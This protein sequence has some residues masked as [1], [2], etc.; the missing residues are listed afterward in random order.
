VIRDIRDIKAPLEIISPWQVAMIAL[1]VLFVIATVI[2]II[3]TLRRKPAEG[4]VRLRSAH[5]IAYEQLETLLGKRLPASGKLKEY[6]SELADI[7]RHYLENRF[8]LR[9]PEMTTEEFLLFARDVSSLAVAHRELLRDFL[10]TCDLV[11]FAK[12][13]PPDTE[14][15][16]AFQIAKKFVDETKIVI[17]QQK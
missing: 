12:Y 13:A 5:E 1:I 6:F 15:D 17:P 16:A 2:L 3:M 14:I 8:D 4:V 7:V 11:K 10:T 9:A